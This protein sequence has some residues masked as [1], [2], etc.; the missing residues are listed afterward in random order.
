MTRPRVRR[1]AMPQNFI[2]CDRDQELL[3]PPSMRE[4]LPEDHLAWFVADAVEEMDLAAFY[5][6]DREDGWGRRC[7]EELEAGHAA[8]MR[9][10][11][12]HLERRADWEAGHGRK[13]AGRKP[14]PPSED[15]LQK[16]KIN[17][18]DPDSAPFAAPP[19]T[20]SRAIT[21]RCGR[22][23][24][25]HPPG[26]RW[27]LECAADCGDPRAGHPGAHSHPQ[28]PSHETTQ[29]GGQAGSPRPSESRTFSLPLRARLSTNEDS[30]SS[31]QSSPT[32]S[33]SAAPPVSN[34][35]D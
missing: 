8:E 30:R 23:V 12:E 25:R 2:E 18:T 7:Q 29:A 9:A 6:A 35:A 19:P 15:A 4:W 3:L 5:G 17:T 20:R 27:L 24:D 14:V 34:G 22:G 10:H 28:R 26:R 21:R 33:S 1:W 16:T 13:L 31:S 32:Q 11:E